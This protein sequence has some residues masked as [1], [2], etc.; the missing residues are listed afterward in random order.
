MTTHNQKT[1]GF[2]LVE[3]LVAISIFI[4]VSVAV[5]QN[6]VTFLD[7]YAR[8]KKKDEMRYLGIQAIEYLERV[9][10][11]GRYFTL[12]GASNLAFKDQSDKNNEI[13][14]DGD[15][16]ICH[17]VDGA[18]RKTVVTRM[19]L[20]D[21]NPLNF[22]VGPSLVT[23]QINFKMDYKTDETHSVKVSVAQRTSD[24]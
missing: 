17:Y 4:I 13:K 23:V 18:V 3:I 11:S 7:E 9:L 8:Q 14:L 20:A 10:R 5:M 6:Y 15:G 24:V 16:N 21:A 22:A 2:T 12:P 19:Y 1:S